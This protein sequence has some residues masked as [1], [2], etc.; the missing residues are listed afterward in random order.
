MRSKISK[1]KRHPISILL[2][3]KGI[4][5][6]CMGIYKKVDMNINHFIMRHSNKNTITMISDKCAFIVGLITFPRLD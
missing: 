6:C 4:V 3:D 5:F 2:E 1:L